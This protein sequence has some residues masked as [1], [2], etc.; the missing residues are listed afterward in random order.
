LGRVLPILAIRPQSL[1]GGATEAGLAVSENFG[2]GAFITDRFKLVVWEATSEPV[3]LFDRDA[4]PSEDR[5][6]IG[7][8]AYAQARDDLMSRIVTPF[9]AG[10]PARSPAHR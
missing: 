8:P 6:V 10:A 7:D 1:A 5:N 9:L 2:F 4:D 3:Q